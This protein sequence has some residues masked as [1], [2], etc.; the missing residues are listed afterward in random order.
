MCEYKSIIIKFNY[1]IENGGQDLP[2]MEGSGDGKT[3]I[4][5]GNGDLADP[6]AS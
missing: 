1:S 6:K 3:R 4:N 2:E 5:L